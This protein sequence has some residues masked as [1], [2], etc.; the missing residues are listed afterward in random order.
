MKSF[1][2]D[3]Y[4]KIT[5]EAMLIFFAFALSVYSASLGTFFT[6]KKILYITTPFIII[7]YAI[8]VLFLAFFKTLITDFVSEFHY[9]EKF[10]FFLVHLVFFFMPMFIGIRSFTVSAI[11]VNFP[12]LLFLLRTQNYARLYFWNSIILL[13]VFLFNPRISP[14][15]IFIFTGLLFTCMILDYFHF[16]ASAYNDDRKIKFRE[17]FFVLI[18]FAGIPTLIG[19]IISHFIPMMTPVNAKDLFYKSIKYSGPSGTPNISALKLMIEGMILV[20]LISVALALLSWLQ[21]KLTKRKAVI[22]KGV[23]SSVH[24]K[25]KFFPT[26]AK[27][28]V[29]EVAG[30][31]RSK[32]IHLYNIFVAD[33]YELTPEK[34][35][36][37]TPLEYAQFYSEQNPER[38]ANI[39]NLTQIFER[40]KYGDEEMF[41]SDLKIMEREIPI[42]KEYSYIKRQNAKKSD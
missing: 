21:S 40:A 39:H 12:L 4:S 15:Y 10:A 1:L 24:E 7:Y 13:S 14:I 9:R 30:D 18:L 28:K 31:I 35:T 8:P 38:A 29:Y 17:L 32:I 20:I 23:K 26:K 33:M 11:A 3:L 27:K 37:Q 5:Y 41:Q 6:L 36:Y 19:F 25:E 2:E 16:K 34:K 42:I 22:V